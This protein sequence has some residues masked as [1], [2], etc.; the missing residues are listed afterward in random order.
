MEKDVFVMKVQWCAQSELLYSHD[1][2][3]FETRRT[4]EKAF[5][6]VE[7]FNPPSSAESSIRWCQG[8]SFQS[9]CQNYGHDGDH[10]G[11]V[12]VRRTL[13]VRSPGFPLQGFRDRVATTLDTP[14]A[15]TDNCQHFAEKV[16]GWAEFAANCVPPSENDGSPFSGVSQLASDIQSATDR[17][18]TETGKTFGKCISRTRS[19]DGQ[20][21]CIET[22]REVHQPAGL[23]SVVP[24][25][26]AS[27]APPT[28][29]AE[30]G[31]TRRCCKSG[32]G[33]SCEMHHEAGEVGHMDEGPDPAYKD[34][35]AHGGVR[36]GISN[37][38][39]SV[40]EALGSAT[41]SAATS[42]EGPWGG[43][44]AGSKAEETS[45]CPQAPHASTEF[46]EIRRLRFSRHPDSLKQALLTSDRLEP[47][48]WSGCTCKLENGAV[49][50]VEAKHAERVQ[51]LVSRHKLGPTDVVVYKEWVSIV[52]AVVKDGTSHKDNVK[53]KENAFLGF[54]PRDDN[55][56]S[57]RITNTFLDVEEKSDSSLA[58]PW[59]MVGKTR[60][61]S[62]S[63]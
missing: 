45:H 37:A 21:S 50:M 9:V 3:V 28:N 32:A 53:L 25:I 26:E 29:G 58:A 51:A 13:T 18:L 24:D 41:G 42:M 40:G 52:E 39:P 27:D 54:L 35:P 1:F 7:K 46:F 2:I 62:A 56:P 33:A 49:L 8:P 31:D 22:S 20:Y 44:M 23:A 47:L 12:S 61:R 34:T 59:I 5:Y 63:P 10:R 57:V 30:S 38:S 11:T 14:W 55:S 43:D 15:L 36:H 4:N 60:G 6:S 17:V 48:N 16:Y 19:A